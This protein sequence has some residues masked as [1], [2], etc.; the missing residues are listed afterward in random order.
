MVKKMQPESES[1]VSPVIGVI[2]MV[3]VTVILAAIIATFVLGMAT[4]IPVTRTLAVTVDAPDAEHL[5]FVYKGGPDAASFSYATVSITPSMGAAVTTWSNTTP[6]GAPADQQYI[7]G[8]KVGNQ[9]L[10]TGSTA[11]FTG[12]DHVVVTGRFNDGTDQ[13]ILNTFI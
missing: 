13:V 3:A 12:K 2:L 7:L 8:N 4:N 9:V 10:A 6:H 1:A 5:V 11:Q